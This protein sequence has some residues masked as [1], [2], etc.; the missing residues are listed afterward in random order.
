MSDP[1][2]A[3]LDLIRRDRRYRPEAYQFLWEA[4]NFAQKELKMGAP[5]VSDLAGSH[6]DP[7]ARRKPERHVTGPEL[8][9]AAR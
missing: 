9:E 3:F 7:A 2:K 4:L 8:C 1:Q 6:E 5:R